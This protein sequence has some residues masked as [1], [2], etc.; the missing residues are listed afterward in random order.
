MRNLYEFL[1]LHTEIKSSDGK[2]LGY[3]KD[4]LRNR[5]LMK[6]AERRVGEF[7]LSEDMIDRIH[8]NKIYLKMS[9]REFFDWWMREGPRYEKE[10]L[11]NYDFYSGKMSAEELEEIRADVKTAFRRNFSVD[12]V[13]QA[14][15][16][17]KCPNCGAVIRK[18]DQINCDYCGLLLV[19]KEEGYSIPLEEKIKLCE[20]QESLRV[21]LDPHLRLL[22]DPEE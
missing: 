10:Y 11:D 7:I 1:G 5:V 19:K 17:N 4:V 16:H 6:V 8:D 3:V 13:R 14:V 2:Y 12:L 18:A 21:K 20:R 22:L 15:F 9:G